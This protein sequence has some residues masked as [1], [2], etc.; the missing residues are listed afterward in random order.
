VDFDTFSGDFT[1][2][3]AMLYRSGG[4]KGAHGEIGSGGS[5]TYKFHTFSGD[6]HL[7]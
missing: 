7:K 5:N 1:S 2:E 3:A 6:V 4:R